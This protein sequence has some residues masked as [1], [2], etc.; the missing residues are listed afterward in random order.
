ME[1]PNYFS[2]SPDSQAGDVYATTFKFASQLPVQYN[3]NVWNLGD[4]TFVYNTSSVE[5]IYN[6]PGFYKV[7]LSAWSDFGLIIT[8]KA[9]INVD[10]VYR[11]ILVFSQIP[12]E[13]GI[14]GVQSIV[15]F[16]VS[17]TSA[18]INEPIS[19]TLQ[20]L[21]TDSVPY[22]AVPD[23]WNFITPTWK[24][25]DAETNKIINQQFFIKT[26]PLYKNSKVVAVTGEASFYYIDDQA[27]GLDLNTS[28]PL[29]LIATLST[30]NFIYPPES[31]IYPY[32]SYSNSEVARAVIAWQIND[33]I[34]T[35]L[36]VTE[37]FISEIYPTKWTNIPIPVMIT[38]EFNP[39]QI[40]SFVNANLSSTNVLAY[41][42]TNELGE[43]DIVNITL[44]SGNNIPIPQEYYSVDES[45]LHF[46][47]YDENNNVTRGYLFTSVTPLS[48]IDSASVLASTVAN[49]QLS[50]SNT[51]L[52]P[53]GYPIYPNAYVSHPFESSIN[54]INL[55]TYPSKCEQINYYK[56]LG[57]LVE[58]T[59]S[60]AKSMTMSATDL[61]NY[62]LTGTAPV[63]GM[64]FNPVKNYLYAADADQDFIYI[65][66]DGTTLLSSVYLGN[67]TGNNYNTPA[68]ISTDRNSNVWVSLYDQQ[69][70]L[71]FDSELN[72]LYTAIPSVTIPLTSTNDNEF[73]GTGEHLI[74]PPV[75]ETDQDNN[76]WA[77]YAHELSSMLVKFDSN[78]VELFMA[79]TLE[80]S[81]VP[82]SL[83]INP[84]KN[85]WVACYNSNRLELYSSVDGSLLSSVQS[86]FIHP[87]YTA[88]DRA[89]NVWF[90][91]GYNFC[92][93]YDVATQTISSWKFD[94]IIKTVTRADEYT[95]EDTQKAINENEIWGGLAVDVFNRVWVVDS[96]DNIVFV[97]NANEPLAARNFKVIP[98]AETN[99]ILKSGET[100]VT[101]VPSD[102]VRSAQAAGDWTGNKWYQKYTGE[103]ATIPI[104]GVSNS[105]QV[106]DI[107]TS[108]QITKVNEEFDCAAYFKSLALPE[109]LSRNT[110]LFDSFLAAVVGDGNPTKESVG[111]VAYERIANF[112]Q[113]HGDFETAE[114][115]QLLAFAKELSIQGNTFGIEF[116]A[117]VNRLLN[118]FSIPKHALR[119][120]PKY[121]TSIEN[122][123]GFYDPTTK[124][125]VTELLTE[126]SYISAGQ[127][128]YFR[129]KAFIEYKLMYVVP[130]D[131]DNGLLS[132]YPLSSLEV[133]GLRE[134]IIDNYY[135][136]NYNP[137]QSGYTGN[138]INWDS[139]YTTINYN[140]STNEDWYGDNGLVEIMFNNLL[141][142]RLFE[143]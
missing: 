82:V 142:K 112:I 122:S 20:A 44:V 94:G 135:F 131:T 12:T 132:V 54:K 104:S 15:P 103:F 9:D 111:R 99:Y 23:K 125:N 62:T 58:G 29:L 81:S 34:P 47:A 67:I 101:D 30:L 22:Y 92:G 118:M 14:P 130:L 17:L 143:Q 138:I 74:A 50:G 113:T 117:E 27:T 72:Y 2:I 55:V 100:F 49:N 115:D 97:F 63:Y 53:V 139:E 57:L 124:E 98:T 52:F 87:T 71:K 73:G 83:S 91:H 19:I 10:Y 128:L 4:N 31:L 51:F 1:T 86:D 24:F 40:S 56:N 114:I 105:F 134:P 16:T 18:K 43:R 41:P 126:T 137:L 84:D 61:V 95:T 121:D 60:F 110:E 45:N 75:A 136:V 8:D 89:G 76:V 65:Y 79:D 119:G 21:N 108:Y 140:L 66:K 5:H 59:V 141:T 13:Y 37:N 116:P 69:R 46:Q 123:L 3:K 6:Y 11:D 77:C 28:C 36:K 109:I 107:D 78:G 7:S 38:C 70:L 25:V 68:Y 88:L 64:A 96:Q 127:Y 33:V 120:I 26:G 42:K 106:Y 32:Y 39:Q 129:D 85:V 35:Q 80:V 93:V 48:P 102:N 133:A 90:T